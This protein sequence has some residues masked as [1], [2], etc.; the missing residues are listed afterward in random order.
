[1]TGRGQKKGQRYR[2]IVRVEVKIFFQPETCC[3]FGKDA[4]TPNALFVQEL[5]LSEKKLPRVQLKQILHAS[6]GSETDFNE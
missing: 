5:Q 6:F 2:E 3:H 1:M 4:I